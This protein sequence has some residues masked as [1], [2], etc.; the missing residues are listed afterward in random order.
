MTKSFDQVFLSSYTIFYIF[1]NFDIYKLSVRCFQLSKLISYLQCMCQ[2]S[3][4]GILGYIHD[5]V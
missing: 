4:K 3:D 2:V 1:F 5:H